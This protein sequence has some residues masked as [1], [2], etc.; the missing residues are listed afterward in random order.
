LLHVDD[1]ADACAFILEL[2]EEAID[3]HAH[4]R[5]LNVGFGS[6]VTIRELA[7]LVRDVVGSSSEM[8]WDA[9]RPD[10]TPR[11]LMDSSRLFSLGWR[12]R[13]MLRAG[14]ECTYRWFLDALT[15]GQA[16][17]SHGQGSSGANAIG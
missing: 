13:I 3:A 10:G 15:R 14:I 2:S 1:L 11:K 12:P 17:L 4:R 5:T 9:T 8:R 16:K 7:E 6:D